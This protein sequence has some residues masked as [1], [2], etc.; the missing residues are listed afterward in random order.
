MDPFVSETDDES[1]TKPHPPSSTR[2]S[3]RK[4]K[5]RLTHELNSGVSTN[6]PLRSPTFGRTKRKISNSFLPPIDNVSLVSK[7]IVQKAPMVV[8]KKTVKQLEMHKLKLQRGENKRSKSKSANVSNKKENFVDYSDYFRKCSVILTRLTS[9]QME[10]ALKRHTAPCREE[11][12][13]NVITSS[14]R[15]GSRLG[16][17]SSTG[18]TQDDALKK[19]T[20]SPHNG[21][22][23]ETSKEAAGSP[24][25]SSKPGRSSSSG[26]LQEDALKKPSLSQ[27]RESLEDVAKET[28]GV[29]RR[30][31]KQGQSPPTGKQKASSYE[32]ASLGNVKTAKE[33]ADSP[34]TNSKLGLSSSTGKNQEDALRKTSSHDGESLE[35]VEMATDSKRSSKQG[36]GSSTDLNATF[37]IPEE[38]IKTCKSILQKSTSRSPNSNAHRVTFNITSVVMDNF[39]TPIPTRFP[40]DDEKEH[41]YRNRGR[42]SFPIKTPTTASKKGFSPAVNKLHAGATPANLKTTDKKVLKRGTM[43]DYSKIHQKMYDKMLNIQ[44]YKDQKMRRA[45]LLLSGRKPDSGTKTNNLSTTKTNNPST[46]K[47]NN[48]PQA[49]SAKKQVHRKLSFSRVPTSDQVLNNSKSVTKNKSPTRRRE[50]ELSIKNKSNPVRS[51]MENIRTEIKGIRSNRRFELLMKFRRGQ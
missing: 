21:E 7:V 25:R 39:N 45:K 30:R 51:S 23:F 44:D 47:T 37:E 19:H 3:I 13:P 43:P 14:L 27:S 10:E 11:E 34:R 46:T 22:N 41:T 33:T 29:S 42:T 24:K 18:K 4:R 50:Q 2:K 9:K 20:A 32:E 8:N 36:R 15:R 5:I 26:K 38:E 6:L 16:R 35:D 31:S 40:S 49:A 1:S 12:V 48:L 28:T 17:S